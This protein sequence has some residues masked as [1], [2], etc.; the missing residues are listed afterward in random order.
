M[1]MTNYQPQ[2]LGGLSE[3]PVV[4]GTLKIGSDVVNY[5]NGI[6][7]YQGKTYLISDAKD[8]VILPDGTPLGAIVNGMLIPL[9]KLSA[10]NRQFIKTKYQI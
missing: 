5:N 4:T 10:T 2:R 8:F 3:V 6:F 7:D 9:D 1:R